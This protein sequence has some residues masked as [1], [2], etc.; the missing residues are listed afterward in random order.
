MKSINITL[1]IFMI[2]TLSAKSQNEQDT[3]IY[4]FKVENLE[5]EEFDF[6]DLKGKKI[7]VVNTASKCGLTPQY[8]KLQALYEKYQE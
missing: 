2:A 6:N 4:Q 8:K 1:L 7:M 3:S 5:G